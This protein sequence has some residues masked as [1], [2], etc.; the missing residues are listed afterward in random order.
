MGPI[1]DTLGVEQGGVCS[2][3]FYKCI[4]N[5]QLEMAQS[6]GLGVS[7]GD[8]GQAEDVQ[9]QATSIVSIISFSSH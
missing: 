7:I 6:S 5:E 2:D 4:N 9:H 1:Q 8:I 3:S